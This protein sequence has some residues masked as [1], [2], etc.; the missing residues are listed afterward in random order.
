MA[1]GALA[2]V[3]AT[4]SAGTVAYEGDTLVIS[5][6]AGELNDLTLSGENPGKLSI[7]E[8]G[9]TYSFPSDRCEQEDPQYAIHCDEPSAVRAELGDLNDRAVVNH[10]VPQGLVVLVRGGD[11]RDDMKVIDG[12]TVATFDGG[13]GDDIL[14]SEEGADV[15]IGGPGDDK[16]TGGAGAD[17]LHGDDGD[18]KLRA[19]RDQDSSPDVLDGGAGVD[20]VDDWGGGPDAPGPVSVTLDG[21]ANDGRPGEGDDVRDVEI[22]NV[23]VPGTFVMGDGPDIV[24]NLSPA[25]AAASRIEGRGGDDYLTGG[26]ASH[27][28][29]GGAGDDRV[30]G[31]FG[32]DTLVGG[33]G[34]DQ[35]FGDSTS[36]NCGGYGQSCTLPTGNDTI[37]ARDGA[38]DTIDCGPGQDKAVVD[39]ADT[40]ANCETVDKPG[41]SGPNG[42]N[43]PNGPCGCAK[44][45]VDDDTVTP[46]TAARVSLAAKPRLRKALRSGLTVRLSG[47]PAGNVLVRA[48]SG[49]RVV[50][51]TRVRVAADG[52][53]TRRLRF[54]KK[55]KR[56]LARKR[57]VRLTV[58]AGAARLVVAL[59]R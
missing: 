46:A 13:A 37:D 16:L 27:T 44:P 26:S 10:T 48:K 58:T 22:L 1:A 45:P 7:S 14:L 57:F 47:L 32:H 55:A 35:I 2:I 20:T 51:A 24:E 43:G 11:G 49:G 18:D 6:S 59:T 42:P 36:G 33:P 52:T 38:A 3:P 39:A 34:S 25:D 31:G 28:I 56:A 50:A 23:Y 19:D 4:A 8:S 17:E 12:R 54:T 41:G 30:E 40:V 53:A 21:Q 15:L 29:D 9:G 5:A